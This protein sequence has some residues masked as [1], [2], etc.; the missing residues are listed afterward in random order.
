MIE[1][2]QRGV[3]VQ[4]H[5]KK[6]DV[7]SEQPLNYLDYQLQYVTNTLALPEMA[8]QIRHLLLIVDPHHVFSRVR[9]YH[10]S[11]GH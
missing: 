8:G 5:P 9:D 10:L 4:K 1:C 7:I 11:N 2:R 3:G 6:N